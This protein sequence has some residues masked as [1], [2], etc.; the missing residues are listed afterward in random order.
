[1]KTT[2][3]ACLIQ[4]NKDQKEAIDRI[5]C[6]YNHAVRVSYNELLR[7]AKAGD[8]EKQLARQTGLTIRHAKDAVEDARQT[9][10]SQTELVAMYAARYE[11]RAQHTLSQIQDPKFQTYSIEKQQGVIRKYEKR[12]KMHLFWLTHQKNNT[13]PPVV[14]GGR[15]AFFDRCKNQITK[16]EWKDKRDGRLCVR[17]DKEKKGNLN[18]RISQEKD[19]WFLDLTLDLKDPKRKNHYQRMRVE[20]YVAEKISKT[21]KKRNGLNFPAMLA[22]HLSTGSAYQVEILRRNGKYRVHISI[23]ETEASVMTRL[24]NGVLG[25]DTNPTGLAIALLTPDGNPRWFQWHGAGDLPSRSHDA[26]RNDVGNLVKQIVLIAKTNGVPIA[27]ENLKHM[28][29]REIKDHKLRRIAHGFCYRLILT[30]IERTAKRIG[31]EV[32]KVHPAYTSVI[33]KVKYQRQYGIST[34]QAA[35]M[36]IGRR[37]QGIRFERVP[38]VIKSYIN[39]QM[40]QKKRKKPVVIDFEVMKNWKQWSLV[41]KYV[42]KESQKQKKAWHTIRKAVG[43]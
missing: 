15:S 30:M 41:K 31:V 32:I 1:M 9:I 40:N 14:F 18:A 11:E 16:Q 3:P 6:S 25:I 7:G 42:D 35:A 28:T 17:G 33:G 5:M 26:K 36:T 10:A 13:H 8:V 24:S 43:C 34:H 22:H 27:M 39:N 20:L 19:R 12:V 2:I 37:A 38:H 29:D 4:L 23:E 21:T